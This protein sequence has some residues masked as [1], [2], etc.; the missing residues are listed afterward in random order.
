VQVLNASRDQKTE[1]AAVSEQIVGQACTTTAEPK[2]RPPLSEA[3]RHIALG[4]LKT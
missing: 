3:N 1:Y 4:S 2:W